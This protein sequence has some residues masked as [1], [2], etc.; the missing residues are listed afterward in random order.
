M[1]N[2]KPLPNGYEELFALSPDS[3]SGAVWR[4][5]GRPLGGVD[6]QGYWVFK[7]NGDRFKVHRLVL[8]LHTGGDRPSRLVDHIDRDKLNNDPRNL[9]WVEPSENIRNRE[10]RPGRRKVTTPIGRTGTRWVYARKSG[11]FQGRFSYG[12][13]MINV[14]IFD[15]IDQAQQAVRAK[16][17]DM[18]LN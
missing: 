18:G 8:A 1:T 16:R 12:D 10:V 13:K 17:D 7:F 14:G 3:P 5:T 11:R 4:A 2:A 6:T 9:R 15:T